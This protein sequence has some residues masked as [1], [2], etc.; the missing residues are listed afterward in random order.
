MPAELP[1][2][3]LLCLRGSVTGRPETTTLAGL[4]S[5]EWRSADTHFLPVFPDSEPKYYV[6]ADLK[7]KL[8]LKV[9]QA[10]RRT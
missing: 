3:A 9:I 8:L 2:T 1:Y 6:A 10:R 4:S 7:A 5:L